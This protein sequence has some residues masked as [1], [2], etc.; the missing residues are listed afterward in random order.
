[1]TR[2]SLHVVDR[3]QAMR[4][5]AIFLVAI[6]CSVILPLHAQADPVF[7]FTNN[8]T[9]ATVTGCSSACRGDITIPS[10]DGLG[11]PVTA[12]G[13]NAFLGNTD[14]TSVVIGEG[15]TSIGNESFRGCSNL[16]S[17]VFP[18]TLPIIA[19]AS[20]FND[21]ALVSVTF[22]QMT[23]PTVGLSA[24]TN[25]GAGAVGRH[26]AAATG[27]TPTWFTDAGLISA[28]IPLPVVVPALVP[29]PPDIA[30]SV[31]MPSTAS[32]STIDDK[33]L[34]WGGATSGGWTASWAQWLNAGK[35][36][37]VCNRFLGF[38]PTSNSWFTRK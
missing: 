35:G 17:V 38:N 3:A 9:N 30:Q 37:A 1:M 13:I 31:G 4:A 7:T 16:T 18:S 15:V 8:G 25:H 10:T 6:L 29:L 20:F 24:F 23:A 12:V 5:L 22:N 33:N 32:C 27:F 19:F 26:Y 2:S 21:F 34:N 36:G 28:I 11:H 14:L